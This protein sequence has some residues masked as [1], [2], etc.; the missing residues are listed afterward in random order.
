MRASLRCTI[1]YVARYIRSFRLNEEM[2]REKRELAD[3]YEFEGGNTDAP[4]LNEM[5]KVGEG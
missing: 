4:W 2:E 3:D 1:A 5:I